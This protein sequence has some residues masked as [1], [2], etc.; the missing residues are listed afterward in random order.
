MLYY[1]SVYSKCMLLRFEAP[2]K[3]GHYHG[4]LVSNVPNKCVFAELSDFHC[5]TRCPD[6]QSSRTKLCS[7]SH[8]VVHFRSSHLLLAVLLSSITK[9]SELFLKKYLLQE[10]VEEDLFM[11]QQEKEWIEKLKVQ[12]E[13]E[14]TAKQQAFQKKVVQP[15]KDELR[16]LLKE[17]GD[18]ISD[19]ALQRL[20]MSKL[21]Y[22]TLE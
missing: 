7:V 9:N 1:R 3:Y 18:E 10:K 5:H 8:I 22:M 16:E 2:F 19:E 4:Y 21:H 12:Q 15:V 20:A 14:T 11:R 6:L 17:T 13:L